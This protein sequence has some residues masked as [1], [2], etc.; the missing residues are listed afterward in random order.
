LENR[1]A[2]FPRLD[3]ALTPEEAALY[4]KH[5]PQQE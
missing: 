3:I 2:V 1:T 5:R 4:M